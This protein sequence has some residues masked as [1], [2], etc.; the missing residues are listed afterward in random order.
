MTVT[1]WA[2]TVSVTTDVADAQTW[3]NRGLLWTYGFNHEEAIRCFQLAAMADPDSAMAYWG[4]A[5]ATGPTT[6]NNGA[7]SPLLSSRKRSARLT[8]PLSRQMQRHSALARSN[9][10]SF[11]LSRSGTPRPL[12]SR[13]AQWNTEYAEALRPVYRRHSDNLDVVS[14]FAESL[15]NLTPWKMCDVITGKPA[16]GADRSPTPKA[17]PPPITT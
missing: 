8:A 16:T 11:A 5:Y 15:M 17:K 2:I 12:P 9:W 1:T 14:L 6:T 10:D 7:S 4:I 3:F 13:T